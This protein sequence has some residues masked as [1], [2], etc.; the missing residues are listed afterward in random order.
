MGQQ[1]LPWV[2][3]DIY[4]LLNQVDDLE[5]T[6]FLLLTPDGPVLEVE[7][8]CMGDNDDFEVTLVNVDGTQGELAERIENIRRFPVNVH[9]QHYNGFD[10]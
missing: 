3:E 5:A 4:D 1:S 10:K 8:A 2:A 6:D 7:I 9:I